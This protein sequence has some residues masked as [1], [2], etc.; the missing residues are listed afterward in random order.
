MAY[1]TTQTKDN[2][3]DAARADY[4]IKAALAQCDEDLELCRDL[5]IGP[6][7]F[8]AKHDKYLPIEQGE[9]A[10]SYGIRLNDSLL[11]NTFKKTLDALVGMGFKVNPVLDT[12]VPAQLRSDLEDVDLAGTHFDVFLRIAFWYAVRDGHSFIMVDSP[13][14]LQQSITSAAPVPDA[15]DDQAAGRRPYWVTYEKHQA[16]NWASDRINGETVLT[17]ITFRECVTVADGEYGEKEKIKYRVL[18]LPKLTEASPGKPATYGPMEWVLFEEIPTRNSKKV[19]LQQVGG[20]VTSLTRIP[21]VVIYTG[22]TGFLI[23]EPPLAGLAWLNLGHYRQW[24]NLADQ[25]R[26]LSP[27]AVRKLDVE[28]ELNK[29]QDPKKHAV[30]QYGRKAVITVAGEHADF[31]YISH[32]PDCIKPAHDF[33]KDLE[34]AM[35]TEGISLIAAKDEREVTA[36]EKSMDQAERMSSLAL[37]VRQCA[38]SAEQ[39]LRFHARYY[40]LND[41]GSVILT[42]SGVTADAV[43]AIEAPMPSPTGAVQDQNAAPVA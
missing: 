43:K 26:Y 36:L 21:V 37:W 5:A 24:S 39:L 20:G 19:E 23:S 33:I 11:F 3:K 32:D 22:K 8:R 18:K 38:D 7:A 30:I 40:G 12:D 6:K 41:G 27:T 9:H 14:P 29:D 13:P 2:T 15:A 42:I 4:R 34:Q 31:K 10:D 28:Q 25:I 16:Y 17:R 1:A 35:S